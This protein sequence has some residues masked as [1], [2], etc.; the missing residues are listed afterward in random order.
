MKKYT[1]TTGW[2]YICLVRASGIS[3]IWGSKLSGSLRLIL[4]NVIGRLEGP[5]IS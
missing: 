5:A 1:I 2:E 4:M 3:T